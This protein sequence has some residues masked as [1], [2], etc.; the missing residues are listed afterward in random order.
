MKNILL[1]NI[2]Q[3]SLLTVLMLLLLLMEGVPCQL[4]SNITFVSRQFE[5]ST[6]ATSMRLL[7]KIWHQSKISTAIQ[8]PSVIT[9]LLTYF[10][11]WMRDRV[12]TGAIPHPVPTT[13]SGHCPVKLYMHQRRPGDFWQALIKILSAKI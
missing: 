10:I 9:Y 8:L 3:I 1:N 6:V 2:R 4:D 12:Q 11:I 5:G 7:E 13:L